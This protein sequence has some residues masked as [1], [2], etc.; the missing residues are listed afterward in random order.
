MAHRDRVSRCLLSV[1]L[2]IFLLALAANVTPVAYSD[3]M[4]H[5][6]DMV[7][8]E[9]EGEGM[10]LAGTPHARIAIDGDANFSDTALLEGWEGDGSPENPYIIDGVDIDLGGNSGS[11]IDISNTR[12]SF[13]ISNCNLTG[14]PP[15]WTMG[16]G[17]GIKLENVANGE[18]V[19]NT[20]NSNERGIWLSESDYNTVVNNTCNDNHID[21]IRLIGTTYSTLVNN[22]CSNSEGGISFSDSDSNTVASNT[23]NNNSQ[24]GIYFGDSDFNTVASNTCNNNTEIGIYLGESDSNTVVNNICNSNDIG[25]SLESSISNTVVNNTLNGCG[26]FFT[27]T[28]THCRQLEVTGNSVNSQPLV[29]LQDQVGNVVSS[30]AGQV[31]LVGCSQVTVKDQTLMN[32]SV[33]VLLCHTNLTTLVNN[34]CTSNDIGI[35]LTESHDNEVIENTCNDNDDSGIYLDNSDSNTVANNI[36]NNYNWFGI[37]LGDSH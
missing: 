25:I 10:L 4:F 20:C 13:I 14:A 18:L 5:Q 9:L 37:I 32:C 34:T 31:I 7:V 15:G 8:S 35:Y 36:C 19:N 28:L 33:G 23:C 12:V 27:G 16:M 24:E 17:A 21:G 29:F 30:P 6:S 11:C 26:F 1:T 22:T 2:S 3:R